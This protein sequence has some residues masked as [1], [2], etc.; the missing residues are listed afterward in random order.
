MAQACT[1]HLNSN[2]EALRAL[3]RWRV[4]MLAY[5]RPSTPRTMQESGHPIRSCRASHGTVDA[6]ADAHPPLDDPNDAVDADVRCR[7]FQASTRILSCRASH[8]TVDAHADAHPPLDEPND[9]TRVD[10]DARFVAH[11][12]WHP[13]IW[14]DWRPSFSHPSLNKAS[15]S[16][17]P[18]TRTFTPSGVKSL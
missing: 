6:H 12:T 16:S 4:R 7:G 8:D 10:V 11:A 9:A 1:R 2:P 3:A 15:P 13:L 14:A 17:D 18:K 5:I